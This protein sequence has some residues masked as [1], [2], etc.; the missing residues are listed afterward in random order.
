MGEAASTETAAA[1]GAFDIA[2]LP[3]RVVL[4][5]VLVLAA[6]VY[7]P[8]LGFGFVYDDHWTILANGFLRSPE[9]LGLLLSPE[10]T[11]RHVPDAFRPTAVLFDMLSYQL[12]G[13]HAHWH[14]LLSVLLHVGVCAALWRWL[15]G[16]GTPLPVTVASV[17]MFAVL[18]IHAEAVAVVSYREDLLAAG[19]GLWAMHA[20]DRASDTDVAR[21]RHLVVCALLQALACGAKTSAVPLPLVWLLSRLVWPHPLG[22]QRWRAPMLALV[23]G[24]AAAL[25][26][27]LHVLGALSPYEAQAGIHAAQWERAGVLAYSVQIHLGYL[28][29]LVLPIGLSPEYV[30]RIASWR[31]PATVLGTAG[32]TL[33]L[34]HASWSARRARVW[35]F[36]AIATLLLWAPTANLVPIPN[37]RADR[38]A[39]LPS[40]VVCF[41]FAHA[42]LAIGARAA[43][44][45]GSSLL[46]TPLLVAVVVQG[47]LAQ[48][49]STAYKSDGRLWEIA[50]RRSPDSARA[51]ALG[52][53]L[54]VASLRAE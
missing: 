41:G 15:A 49:A 13:A 47:A 50:L 20:A 45:W 27:Q 19:L 9:D 54:L 52:G 1:S 6:L 22:A 48:A 26:Q 35:S 30:D 11:Q 18:G 4:A 16:R 32:L 40:V 33:A 8:T 31:D 46:V 38:F 21:V 39:Y 28:Q 44:R 29:Q 17:A 42:L 5:G 3:P 7:L 51:H 34:A 36:V 24:T 43:A 2:R 23:L 53:E 12:F 25:A 10:A 14:H 37:M